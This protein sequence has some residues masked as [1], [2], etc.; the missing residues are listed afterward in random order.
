MFVEKEGEERTDRVESSDDAACWR[1]TG[2]SQQRTLSSPLSILL[3]SLLLVRD[4]CTGRLSEWKDASPTED[5]RKKTGVWREQKREARDTSGRGE[6][7]LCAIS[8]LLCFFPPT[9]KQ[10]MSCICNRCFLC[11]REGR[12]SAFIPIPSP[13]LKRRKENAETQENGGEFKATTD[14]SIERRAD[15]GKEVTHARTHIS[16]H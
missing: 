6:R 9:A 11:G 2:V 15:P 14:G 1:L 4:Q 7:A 10:R 13:I 8:P 16:D 12:I 3:L 5:E